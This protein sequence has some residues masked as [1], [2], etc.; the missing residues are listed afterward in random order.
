MIL[1]LKHCIAISWCYFEGGGYDKTLI[2]ASSTFPAG[3]TM[4][5]TTRPTGWSPGCHNVGIKDIYLVGRNAK[6]IN[7]VDINDGSYFK[8]KRVR[9][10]LFNNA[11]SF[12]KWID[13]TRV[14]TGGVTTYPNA[15]DPAVGGQSY[16]G[17]IE[18]C[19][20]GNCVRCVQFNGVFKQK[21]I[22]KQHVGVQ[23]AC[24]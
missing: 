1:H 11:F 8:L 16:F 15:Y 22:Y 24:I 10:D 23:R 3:S 14:T 19:Y 13:D 21:H 2:R 9:A 17:V 4:L 18:Q 12:N 7:A 20:A 5:R 6:D